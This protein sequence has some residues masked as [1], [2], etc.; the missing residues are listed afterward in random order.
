[1]R[2]DFSQATKDTIARRVNFLCSNPDCPLATVGPHSDSEKSVNRGVA[3]HIT[4][5]A[6]GGKRYDASLTPEQRS[7]ANNGIWLCQ[8]CAKVIDSDE[9]RYTVKVLREWKATAEAKADRSIKSSSPLISTS[10]E[11][12]LRVRASYAGGRSGTHVSLNIFN[13]GTSPTYLA[14]WYSEWGDR[15]SQMSLKCVRG[16]LPF[17]LRARMR[18]CWLL[19]LAG[20]VSPT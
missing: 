14:A 8:N 16:Q 5:A 11:G 7:S 1:M 4:A 3:A 10:A 2:D 9:N 19:T 12:Q 17:R 13:A 18:S 20:E 6:P 15:S